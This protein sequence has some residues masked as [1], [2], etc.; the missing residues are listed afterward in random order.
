MN[1]PPRTPP[2]SDPDGVD[3]DDRRNTDAAVESGKDTRDPARARDGA[4][5]PDAQDGRSRDD[6]SR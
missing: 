4:G 3:E 6:R 1:R 2:H 5:K